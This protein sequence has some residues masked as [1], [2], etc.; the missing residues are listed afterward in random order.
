MKQDECEIRIS[1]MNQYVQIK[2]SHDRPMGGIRGITR[3]TE[4]YQPRTVVGQSSISTAKVVPLDLDP[5]SVMWISRNGFYFPIPVAP[6]ENPDVSQERFL[7][8]WNQACQSTTEPPTSANLHEA[9]VETSH[10]IARDYYGAVEQPKEWIAV[11][12]ALAQRMGKTD[13][14]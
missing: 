5:L 8:S 1:K 4:E 7:G 9:W 12:N 10:K 14:D 6:G 11:D 2:K 3:P 13:E